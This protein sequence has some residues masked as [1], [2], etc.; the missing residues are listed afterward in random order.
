MRYHC[1][2]LDEDLEAADELA[3][4]LETSR[5]SAS[6]SIAGDLA[7]AMEIL[8]KR[9]VDLLFIRIVAWDD[10]R[11]VAPLLPAAPARVVFLSGRRENCTANL[12][13]EVDFHLKPPFMGSRVWRIFER[14]ALPGFQPRSLDF[15]FL[16]EKC[17]YH[18]VPYASI[19][20]IKRNGVTIIIRT[21][22]REYEVA[23]SLE[24]MQV[25]LPVKFERVTR[26]LLVAV[27]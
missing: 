2:I 22:D 1:C 25:R 8:S 7:K 24:R 18:A 10:Y 23:G 12:S 5:H 6:V 4:L 9:A 21:D 20:W 14:L 13:D 16:R 15:L 19:Q 3:V 26:G 11:L 17:R 27:G